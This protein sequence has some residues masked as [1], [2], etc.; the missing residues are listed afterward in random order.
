MLPTARIGASGLSRSSGAAIQRAASWWSQVEMGPPDAILGVTE[1]FKKDT[2]PKKINLGVGAYRDDNGKPFVLPSVIK[3]EEQMRARKLDHEYGAIGGTAEF[4]KH[5]ITLALGDDSEHVAN[6]FNAS[7]QGISGTGSLRI[8][9]AF[10]QKFFPG[11]KVIYLPTPSWGNH[12]PIFKHSGLEVKQYRYYDPKT[13]GFDF[14]GALQDIAKIP[15]KSIILLHAC[16]H[17]PTGVDPRI[18]QWAEMSKVIKEKQLFPF[19]DM[20]YQGFA[21]GDVAKDAAAVRLFLKDGHQIA[22]AQS[23][24]KNMGLY[25]ERA[26]AFS[27]V[28]DSKDD[29]ARTLSQ[30][31][32]IIRPMYSNPPIHGARIVTEILGDANLK[33]IWLNDVK[34]MAER[35]ISMRTKLRDNLAKEGS[36]RNWQ[37][38]TEQIGMFCFTGMN[39]SQVEQLTSKY[40]VYL[41]KDGRISIA[42]VTSQNVEYLAHAMHQVTK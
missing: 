20:A 1:A 30:I 32:I 4:C 22:L 27:L 8:G 9:G 5:S 10:L 19:F 24:A 35:I 33:S 12:T 28:T 42:G 41:T 39:P 15:D 2:N 13:C 7:V 38:I 37:H 23:F 11:N 29:A 34:G 21:S 14:Q 18:E 31:K 25:G 26:G 16:A 40:S 3:A 6:G 36:S 17:N